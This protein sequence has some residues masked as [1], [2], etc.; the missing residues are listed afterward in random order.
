M[1]PD[2]TKVEPIRE[3]FEDEREY[4][5]AWVLHYGIAADRTVD[6]WKRLVRKYGIAQTARMEDC[7][8]SEVKEWAQIQTFKD[9]INKLKR[10]GQS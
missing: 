8:Q 2:Y 1:E 5:K 10:K 3:T 4:A 6:Q 7:T 9:R